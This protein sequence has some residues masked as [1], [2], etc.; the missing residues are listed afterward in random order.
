MA[1]VKSLGQYFTVSDT[2]QQFVFDK[3]K[4]KGRILLEPSFGAG[5]LLKKFL[6]Y[7]SNYPIVCYDIDHTIKPIIPFNSHQIPIYGDFRKQLITKKYKTIIGNPPFVKQK[8]KNLYIHFVEKCFEC[9]DDNGEFIFI[10]PSDFIKL[11]SAAPII[12]KMESMGSFTDFLFPHD[13]RLFDKASVDVLVFRY[14]KGLKTNECMVNG[15]KKVCNI[16]DGVITFSSQAVYGVSLNEMFSVHVGMVSGRDA[17]YKNRIGNIDV[18]TDKDKMEKFIFVENYP[19]SIPAIDAHL[20][21][22]KDEL[23]G[24][25]IKKFSESNWFEWGAPRNLKTIRENMGKDCIYIR[26]ITRQKVVAFMDKVQYYGGS[27]I[28][29][30]PK[31]RM[32]LKKYVEHFNSSVF[33]SDYMYAGRFKIGHRQ[34]CNVIIPE[35]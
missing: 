4:H 25:K 30:I 24:R 21:S 18:L 23:I 29:L 32:D 13:E 12:Q 26:T 22:H 8:G 15:E 20:L 1:A 33:Q 9:L 34:L 14:E 3:V 7:N 6:E 28:C 16:R 19:S 35:T 31:K 11:T 5:H 17:V 10:V 27:L 2:L